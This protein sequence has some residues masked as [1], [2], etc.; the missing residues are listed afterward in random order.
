MGAQRRCAGERDTALTWINGKSA[1]KRASAWRH[2]PT[3]AA[4]WCSVRLVAHQ[5]ER[6]P[7]LHELG[8]SA[9]AHLLHH[10]RAVEFDRALRQRE[11]ERDDL[12]G[13]PSTIRSAI[14][15]SRGVKVS[16]RCIVVSRSLEW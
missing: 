6:D 9:N 13:L 8:D 11:F 1:G 10:A 15:R 4:A 5:V 2:R 3:G 14:S 7:E 16:S 12:V